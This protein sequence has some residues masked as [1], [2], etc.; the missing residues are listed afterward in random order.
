M[1][2]GK[3]I[4][5]FLLDAGTLFPKELECRASIANGN[6]ADCPL[7]NSRSTEVRNIS[8]ARYIVKYG[9]FFDYCWNSCEITDCPAYKANRRD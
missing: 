2:R 5:H 6:S 8:E 9:T 3:N 1:R 7:N 4:T